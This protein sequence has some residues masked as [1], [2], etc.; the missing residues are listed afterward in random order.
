MPGR[1]RSNRSS[2]GRGLKRLVG[3]T[4]GSGEARKGEEAEGDREDRRE[5]RLAADETLSVFICE[6]CGYRQCGRERR[7]EHAEASRGRQSTKVI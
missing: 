6:D 4:S 1:R 5:V 7:K 2:T 3:S